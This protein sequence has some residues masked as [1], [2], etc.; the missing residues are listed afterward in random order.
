MDSTPYVAQTHESTDFKRDFDVACG[1]FFLQ[2]CSSTERE[3]E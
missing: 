1:F 3:T 2:V